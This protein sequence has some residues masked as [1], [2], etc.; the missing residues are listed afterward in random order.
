[1]QNKILSSWSLPA[2]LIRKCYDPLVPLLKNYINQSI[3]I[4]EMPEGV[5]TAIRQNIFLKN[6]QADCEDLANYRHVSNQN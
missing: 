1:M 5:K 3:V 6:G 2:S 4:G